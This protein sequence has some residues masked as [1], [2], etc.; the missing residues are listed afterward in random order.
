MKEA[1]LIETLT[2][3]L[4]VSKKSIKEELNWLVVQGLVTRV[5]ADAFGNVTNA[6]VS[7]E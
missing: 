3:R 7:G 5:K 1:I 2:K 4:G 6:D